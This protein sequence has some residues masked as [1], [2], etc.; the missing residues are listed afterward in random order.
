MQLQSIKKN[1]SGETEII[2]I[3]DT[4]HTPHKENPEFTLEK[5]MQFIQ[6]LNIK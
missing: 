3:P 2:L 1:T 6:K 5:S 4:R